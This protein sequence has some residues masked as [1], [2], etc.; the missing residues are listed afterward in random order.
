VG[1][2]L[3]D[4]GIRQG[5]SELV[6]GARYSNVGA[7]VPVSHGN[8]LVVDD[9]PVVSELLELLL[10]LEGHRVQT[11]ANG[12]A[13]L[14][15]VA[16]GAIRPDLILTDFNLP[17]GM[18]GIAVL[19]TLWDMICAS[20]PVVIFTGDI[21][22][23]A[24]ADI[25]LHDCVQLSKPANKVE[26][27]KVMSRLLPGRE[28]L[29]SA[30]LQGTSNAVSVIFV[31][32]DDEEVRA[33]ICDVLADK[34]RT[35][36]DFVDAESFL[37]AYRPG[38]EGCL[39]LDAYLPGMSG[40]ELL[41]LL[42]AGEDPLP[43]ILFTGRSDVSTAVAAMRAG[44]SDYIEKPVSHD[45]LLASIDRALGQS[46]EIDLSRQDHDAAVRQISCLTPRQR[47]VM[48]LVLAGHPSKNIASDL[49]ISQRTVENHRASIMHK[50][51]TKSLPE[52]ARLAVTAELAEIRCARI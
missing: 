24:L 12:S 13:A 29:S 3:F 37:A 8:I 34:G 10:R 49:G 14:K 15:L 20:V 30:I 6:P 18:N 21:S 22:I 5:N 45:I 42:R 35:V 16:A 27:A 36:R 50:T 9:D 19:E 2:G 1:F 7:N 33:T 17:G 48:Q 52:L 40:V 32:E 47:Q 38:G 28:P 31:V 26:P 25:S 4:W 51:G 46:H 23:E 44:A 39:L 43:T 41:V 11:A